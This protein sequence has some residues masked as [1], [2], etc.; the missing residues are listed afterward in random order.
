MK[1]MD[2][3]LGQKRP[4]YEQRDLNKRMRNENAD[5]DSNHAAMEEL[6]QETGGQAFY[7]TN[8]LNDV[9]SRVIN[10]GTRYYTLT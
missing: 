2:R 8:G 5:R 4:S 10:N 7:N 1:P 9:L 3:R 6:A